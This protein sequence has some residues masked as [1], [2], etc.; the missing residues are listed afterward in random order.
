MS[1]NRSTR[2]LLRW[3]PNGALTLDGSTGNPHV[4]ATITLNTSDDTDPRCFEKV[5]FFYDVECSLTDGDS[6]CPGIENLDPGTSLITVEMRLGRGLRAAHYGLPCGSPSQ[7]LRQ[8]CRRQSA[9]TGRGCISLGRGG[10]GIHPSPAGDNPF[11]EQPLGRGIPA[12]NRKCKPSAP[13]ARVPLPP[14]YA[15]YAPR[16]DTPRL[17]DVM[18]FTLYAR[19]LV[20]QMTEHTGEPGHE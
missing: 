19:L 9:V 8:H 1:F 4:N 10:A 7:A 11:P 14:C 13:W 12:V 17:T 20:S 15:N 3:T 18:P 16:A 2:P 5:F 6:S